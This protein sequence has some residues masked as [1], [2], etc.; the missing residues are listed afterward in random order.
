MNSPRVSHAARSATANANRSIQPGTRL[1]TIPSIN[2]SSPSAVAVNMFAD[3]INSSTAAAA[4]P[5]PDH[6]ALGWVQA[7]L[8]GVLGVVGIAGELDNVGIALA[9]N[10]VFG[11]GVGLPALTLGT[12]HV[13]PLH[14]HL[15]P[16]SCI[17]PA[18]PVPLPS[19]GT[20]SLATCAS[21]L[22]G[23]LPAVRAGDMGVAITC[24]SLSP[25]FEVATGSSN[26]FIGGARAGRAMD[27]TMHCNPL[28]AIMPKAVKAL[29]AMGA[30]GAV[31]GAV[32]AAT[33]A[34]DSSASAA[35]GNAAAAAGQ[36]LAAA[37]GA[38][39]AALDVAALA[40][41][42]LAGKD[43]G[44]APGIG[45]MVPTQGSVLIGGVPIPNSWEIAGP[46]FRA[47]R[48]LAGGAMRRMRRRPGHGEDSPD[49]R[50]GTQTCAR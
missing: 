43:P 47:A 31:L 19:L 24:G 23:G 14:A 12:M 18:P 1:V 38:A 29:V 9:A 30:A 32:G 48:R 15:H 27:L 3:A 22:I 16:P 21:V 17:P 45:M 33:S 41:S 8:G 11:N 5:N 4:M 44:I 39:Q 40:L 50:G 28:Q 2:S 35:E 42:M 7:A 10:A 20:V 46:L 6:G 25:T 49:R 34:M 26:V 13:G 37:T 36:A